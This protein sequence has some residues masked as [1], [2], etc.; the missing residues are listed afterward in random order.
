MN[1][2]KFD[3]R[4]IESS[5]FGKVC[6][7]SLRRRSLLKPATGSPR[8]SFAAAHPAGYALNGRNELKPIPNSTPRDERIANPLV[9]LGLDSVDEEPETLGEATDREMEDLAEQPEDT[10]AN[11]NDEEDIAPETDCEVADEDD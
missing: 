6:L 10:D 4:P 8:K 5:L 2:Q 9:P 1:A 7:E 3:P 11:L